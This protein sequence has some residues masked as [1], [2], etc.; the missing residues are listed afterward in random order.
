MSFI[1]SS[2]PT[3]TVV[4]LGPVPPILGYLLRL[5]QE[6]RGGL[7]LFRRN[8]NDGCV[9]D[10]G[11][12]STCFLSRSTFILNFRL[13]LFSEIGSSLSGSGGSLSGSG[14]SLNGR[15]KTQ[16]LMVSLILLP[17]DVSAEGVHIR[18]RLTA[19][20]PPSIIS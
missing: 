13:N 6:N 4:D 1:L 19:R 20:T 18:K 5:P 16:T 15:A 3:Y 11:G 14:R 17:P 7:K 8:G 9:I 10:V 2:E 12:N